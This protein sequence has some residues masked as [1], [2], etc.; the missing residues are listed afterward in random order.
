[1][2]RLLDRI[3]GPEDLKRM[4]LGELRQLAREIRAEI[5]ETVARNGG[6][7]AANLGTV[8]LAVALHKVF[9]SPRDKILWDVGHQAY[10]HKLVTGRL[11][12]FPTLRK[13]GGL[14]GFL[15]RSESEHDVWEAGHA[16]TALSGAIGYATARDLLRQRHKVVAVVG[17]GALTAG[18]ALEA[19]N[20]IGQ[21]RSD[22]IIVLNDN[23]MSI[24]PNVGAL[25][26]YLAA[27]RTA[28]G[29][30]RRKQ[31]LTDLLEAI[32]ALG[33]QVARA[34]ERLKMGLKQLLLPGMWFEELGI[35]YLG[36]IDGHDLAQLIEVLQD[37]KRTRGPVL[38]H[39]V[40][41]KGHGYAP[42]E[43][44]PEGFH[45]PGP[46]DPRTGRPLPKPAG[47]PSYTG[48]FSRTLTRL[49]RERPEVVAITAA[50]PEGTGL[51]L[52]AREFP[53]RFFDVGIA[54]QHAVTFAAGLA[55]GGLRP[56]VAIYSTFLQ[57]AVDSIIHDVC[58]QKL[59]VVFAIDR[60]GLVG[61][62]GDT[63]QG[64]F[65]LTFL[66]MVPEMAILV[67]RDE[68]ALQHAVATAL[69]HREGP[70]AIRYPRGEGVGVPLDPEPVA[71][72][73]GR[74]EWLREG[75]DVA[76]LAVGPAVHEALAAAKLLE[77][78]GVEASV[79]DARWVKPLDGETLERVATSHRAL[80]T[81]EPGTALG[82]FGSAVL[83]WLS[84]HGHWGVRTRLLGLP[85]RFIEHGDPVL[86]Y[87]QFGLDAAGI[88]RAAG[89][90]LGLNRELRPSWT[91]G[92]V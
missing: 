33:P 82:G 38:V 80:V 39:A 68:N 20:N 31:E 64:A 37:A 63:H 29:Y 75:K 46:F 70:I 66:R 16:G 8:E 54:E 43:Q 52:F 50:M 61:A 2:E 28:P 89:E 41:E 85:D 77:G 12:R 45:G 22:L 49:A 56:V 30:S 7:L 92:E 83:E 84:A 59:P 79:I 25:S 91:G 17:D 42:A 69:D 48:V 13:P 73:F 36:P 4:E 53:E 26:R 40:T 78:A 10:P 24:S 76:L 27:I 5:I 18:L 90:L 1:M 58:H 71:L 74:A 60:A 23:S 88:A 9:S 47:A 14:S 87:H 65:D 55:L 51:S 81:V 57:R 19:L 11:G 15:K 6:H 34:A 3:R 32:P 44:N 35:K 86:Q 67:P 21:S 62:D 72:P